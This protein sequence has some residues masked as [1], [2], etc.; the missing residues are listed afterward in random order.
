VYGH[1]AFA[2]LISLLIPDKNSKMHNAKWKMQ[3]G[4]FYMRMCI[5][6]RALKKK[7]RLYVRLVATAS[8]AQ[9]RLLKW[10]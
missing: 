2:R 10:L 8:V 3:A 7:K 6:Q 9:L 1:W 5:A 4:G